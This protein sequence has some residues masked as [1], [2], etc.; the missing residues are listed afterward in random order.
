MAA[1]KHEHLLK[2][3][4]DKEIE[5]WGHRG[6]EAGV[7]PDVEGRDRQTLAQANT[8]AKLTS[9]ELE[10]MRTKSSDSKPQGRKWKESNLEN[11]F[12]IL[13]LS[14]SQDTNLVVGNAQ[15]KLCR[16]L[17]FVLPPRIWSCFPDPL[18]LPF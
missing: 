8:K 14:E 6:L 3:M 1:K 5:P 9:G 17:D 18:G 7:H 15:Y 13:I 12:S 11:W 2:A 16:E 4:T 10:E